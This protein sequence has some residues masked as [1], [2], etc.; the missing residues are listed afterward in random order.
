MSAAVFIV[1]D[2]KEPGFDPFVN[3]KFIAKED[4][5]IDKIAKKL[6]IRKIDEFVC[7]DFGE[8]S[9]DFDLESNG[10]FEHVWFEPDEGIEW[11][12]MLSDHIDKN[13]KELGNP[14]GVLSDLK[15]YIEVFEKAKT[16][17]AKWHFEL[18]I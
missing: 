12:A 17:G 2:N 13:P 1:L 7:Q 8:F 4:V 11:A 5:K 18:D 10:N 15:E 3:G 9:D 16:I 14:D 6:E